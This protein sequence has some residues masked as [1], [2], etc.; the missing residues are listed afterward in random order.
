MFTILP[1]L[2]DV[3]GLAPTV[4]AQWQAGHPFCDEFELQDALDKHDASVKFRL[5]MGLLI[6]LRK[7]GYEEVEAARSAQ[8][9]TADFRVRA[10]EWYSLGAEAGGSAVTHS[11]ICATSTNEM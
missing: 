5:R 9:A 1:L 8:A 2:T 7:A 4:Q 3:C 10:Y 6:G 11:T